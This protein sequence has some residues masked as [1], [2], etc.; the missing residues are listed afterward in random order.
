MRAASWASDNG[1]KGALTPA[2]PF[3]YVEVPGLVG[4][5]V[6]IKV[7]GKVRARLAKHPGNLL[8]PSERSEICDSIHTNLV[9]RALLLHRRETGPVCLERCVVTVKAGVVV[10]WFPQRLDPALR[11]GRPLERGLSGSPGAIGLGGD[12][13]EGARDINRKRASQNGGVLTQVGA[14]GRG[15]RPGPGRRELGGPRATCIQRATR[16]SLRTAILPFPARC[17]FPHVSGGRPAPGRPG[18]TEGTRGRVPAGSDGASR[19]RPARRGQQ[20]VQQPLP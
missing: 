6:L 5:G 3:E 9:Q 12:H 1:W 10:A 4:P 16:S 8:Q 13:R 14:W 17:P 7:A 18:S 20:S 11:E 15:A 19:R 2:Q